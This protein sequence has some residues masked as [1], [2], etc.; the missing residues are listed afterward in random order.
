MGVRRGDRYQSVG[1][2]HGGKGSPDLVGLLPDG[3]FIGIEIKIKSD[4]LSNDQLKFHS[5]VAQNNGIA[6]IIRDINLE[7][8]LESL[9]VICELHTPGE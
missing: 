1:G 7:D 5:I 4:K 6:L 3:V 9:K 8:G 2:I